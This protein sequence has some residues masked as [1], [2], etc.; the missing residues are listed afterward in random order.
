MNTASVMQIR[1]LPVVTSHI[2]AIHMIANNMNIWRED[3]IIEDL[4]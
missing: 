3:L 4:I 2:T 1:K